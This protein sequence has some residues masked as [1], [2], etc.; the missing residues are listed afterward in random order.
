MLPLSTLFSGARKD[1]KIIHLLV[2]QSYRNQE[3]EGALL[4]IGHNFFTL[5]MRKLTQISKIICLKQSQRYHGTVD[6]S[7]TPLCM[8]F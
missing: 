4:I 1:L 3:L 5:G 8:L 7:I 2:W 6:S